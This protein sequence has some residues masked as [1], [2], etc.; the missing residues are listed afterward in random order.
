M[1]YLLDLDEVL[2]DFEG[3]FLKTFRQRHPELPFIPLEERTTTRIPEQYPA[4]VTPLIEEI[5]TE[6]GFFLSFEPITGALEAA[7]KILE[8]G[9][10]AYI[11]TSPLHKSPRCYT[12]KYEWVLKY[13]GREWTK[14]L[15]ITKDKTLVHG[16][17]LVDDRP[18]IK[19]IIQ[20]TWEHVLY[21]QPYN[22]YVKDKRRL[23]WQEDWESILKI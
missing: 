12:E 9:H 1:I 17:I 20:P 22:M 21:T 8:K 18:E 7:K 10:Q 16:D 6:K 14:R 13:L 15:I 11:C 19:G 3:G 4:E 23:T 2:A 5:F